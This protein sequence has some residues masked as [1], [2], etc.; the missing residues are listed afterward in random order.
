MCARALQPTNLM[1]AFQ[2]ALIEEDKLLVQGHFYRT[3]N[4]RP[5]PCEVPLA[6]NT[7]HEKAN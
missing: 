2:L 6:S 7:I 4:A 3:T 5:S 1:Y